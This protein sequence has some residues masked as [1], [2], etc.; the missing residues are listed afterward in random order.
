MPINTLHNWQTEF[1]TWLPLEEEQK[2]FCDVRPRTF[3][4]YA[5]NDSRI[6]VT[7][8][9]EVVLKWAETGGVLLIGYEMFRLLTRKLSEND[10]TF[11]NM[12]RAL[13][14]PGADL[15][16]CDE[17]HRIKNSNAEIS[18]ALNEI[19]SKRRIVL[20]GY[21]LQNNLMEYWC[22]V[23]FV[24]P[25]FLGSKIEF[26]DIFET[27]I[28]NGKYSDS[29]SESIKL[30]HYRSYALN[31]ILRPIVQR[32]TQEGSLP[33]KHDYVLPLKM[34]KIQKDLYTAFE[35]ETSHNR[36]QNL[37]VM[38]TVGSKIWNHPDVLKN[39]IDLLRKSDE[40][41]DMNWATQ[42]LK[43]YKS[44]DID[45]SAKIQIFLCILNESVRLGDKV[46]LFSQSIRTLDLIEKFLHQNNNMEW[47]KNTNYYRKNCL[48]YS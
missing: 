12:R 32:R 8:R 26:S 7:S 4:V 40:L 11:E 37:L 24:S 18:V 25:N 39:H 41:H 36:F 43:D 31:T 2:S 21:P 14:N 46:L 33:E 16:V 20:T 47:I 10:E 17:G 27:P 19:R 30:M 29:S 48:H 13:T 35:D 42:I 23:N 1:N 9:S 22:M 45:S 15:V 3:K 28:L 6:T 34:T 38:F 5:L 44:N